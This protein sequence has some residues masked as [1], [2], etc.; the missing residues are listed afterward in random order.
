MKHSS[1][2]LGAVA[3]ALMFASASAQVMI[4][5]GASRFDPPPPPP[6][7]PPKIDVP[8]IPQMD[9]PAQQTNAPAPRA[10]FGDRISKCLDDAAASGLAPGKRSAY[11]RSCANR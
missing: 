4:P 3:A 11:S 5:P 1:V 8:K 6:P 10:S 9:A 7:P 2:M